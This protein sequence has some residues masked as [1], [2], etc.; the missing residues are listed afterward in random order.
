MTSP[1]T[2]YPHRY[3]PSLG[4]I[5][6]DGLEFPDCHIGY[7][8]RSLIRSESDLIEVLLIKN[9]INRNPSDSI[10]VFRCS[11]LSGGP[12]VFVGIESPCGKEF[13]GALNK[14]GIHEIAGLGHVD[15][16]SDLFRQAERVCW[17][18]YWA[19]AAQ[20]ISFDTLTEAF[21]RFHHKGFHE[22]VEKIRGAMEVAIFKDPNQ[23]YRE[24][25]STSCPQ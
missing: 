1:L 24:L 16:G 6:V 13:L 4:R 2:V 20:Y 22:G 11:S 23:L 19:H 18:V 10:M 9:P 21:N 12:G 25:S 17:G 5:V 14:I 8:Y 15:P 3:F 7:S